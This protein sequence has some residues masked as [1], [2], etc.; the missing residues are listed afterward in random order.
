MAESFLGEIRMFAGN[1]A[2]HNWAYCDGQLMSIAQH[3]A[4][5]SLLGTV[6]G[7][8]G[9]STFGIPDLRGRAPIHQGTG[10]GLTRRD[11]GRRFGT[12]NVSLAAT[13]MPQHNHPM[14]ASLDPA[15]VS[16]PENAVI[17][18]QKGADTLFG[19]GVVGRMTE[20]SP[21]AV[22]Y[23]GESVPHENMMPYLALNFIICLQGTYPQ[24]S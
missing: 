22:D 20:L 6:Y 8:D 7:G 1:F 4:L 13:E 3:D 9:R 10:V 2:P 19:P 5:Y 24:R 15:E 12:E 14:Q 18:S 21:D 23:A 16:S 11:M 17:A